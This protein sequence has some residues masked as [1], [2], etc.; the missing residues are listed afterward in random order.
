MINDFI[1][2]ATRSKREEKAKSIKNN[3][4][5]DRENLGCISKNKIETFIDEAVTSCPSIKEGDLES[6]VKILSTLEKTSGKFGI[7]EKM[8]SFD[9]QDWDNLDAIISDW[10]VAA[11]KAVLDEIQ[12]RL[13]MIDELRKRVEDHNTLE[14]QD[15][16]PIME[17]CLWVFGPEF[18]SIEYTSNISIARCFQKYMDKRTDV[19]T[20]GNRPDFTIIPESSVGFYST[21]SYGDDQVENGIS[22]LI[23]LELKAPSVALSRDDKAQPGKYYDEFKSLGMISDNTQ[24]VAYLLGSKTQRTLS[25]DTSRENNFTIRVMLFPTL[26]NQAESRLFNL[27]RKIQSAPFLQKPFLEAH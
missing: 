11:A 5:Q 9:P 27:R 2:K 19:K 17:K 4:R 7:I 22:K 21:P 14:V 12:G 24:V 18:D 13:M 26:L 10:T 25:L 1:L 16:Q 8:A 20:S 23:I 6:L 3:T 15:L